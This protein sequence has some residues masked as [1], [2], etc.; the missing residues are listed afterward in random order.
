MTTDVQSPDLV[1]LPVPYAEYGTRLY[2][3][4]IDQS[5][6]QVLGLALAV[7][8]G[9]DKYN[10]IASFEDIA[11]FLTE[12][13]PIVAG[14]QFFIGVIYGALMEAS[15]WQATLGKRSRGLTVETGY[16]CR[17]G[18]F[19]AIMRN[20][21]INLPTTVLAVWGLSLGLL[22]SLAFLTPLIAPKKQ[23]FYDQAM[24]VLVLKLK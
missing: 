8:F 2:A 4:L 7:P 3:Y 21:A 6:I 20:V 14:L 19:T 9:L 12:M 22:V 10:Q 1:V 5:I 16:G 17:I 18:Y 13:V 15:P 23:T 24:N 11:V